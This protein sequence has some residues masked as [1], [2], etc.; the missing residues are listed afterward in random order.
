MRGARW[1]LLLAIFA[2]VGWLGFTYRTQ[3]REIEKQAPARPDLLPLDIAGNAADWHYVK[4]DQAG[5]KITE[6]W[7]RSFK[8]EKDSSRMELEGIRLHLF[9]QKTSQ[10]DRVESPFAIFQP[11]EDKL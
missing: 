5:R 8:Q 9:H 11:K 7:A 2:I 3:R 4:N 10:Y 6:V 1:L